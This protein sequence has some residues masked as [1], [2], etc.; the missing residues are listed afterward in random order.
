MKS[1]ED[2][3][4]RKENKT[5]KK[6]IGLIFSLLLGFCAV[7]GMCVS[8]SISNRNYVAVY[9]EP[10]DSSDG[11]A[12]STPAESDP[13]EAESEVFE[14]KVIIPEFEH[15]KIT[16]DKLEG[17]AGDIVTLEVKHSLFYLIDFVKANDVNLVEDE[18]TSG[19]YKFALVEGDNNI[20][21]KFI[22]DTELLGEMSVIY[23][24]A[25]NKDWTNLFSVENIFR[26]ASF[27]LSSGLLLAMVRYFI[28]DKRLESKVE[29]KV[30]STMKAIVPDM[31]KKVV[32]E[33]I[34]NVIEPIFAE[35]SANQV[36]IMRVLGALV[37]C[38]ALMQEDTPESRRAVLSELANLNIGDTK[39]I[40]DAK[41]FI[42]KYFN[43]KMNEL[44]GLLSSVDK[45]IEKNK[46]VANQYAKAPA[47][48]PEGF[49]GLSSKKDNGTQI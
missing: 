20:S 46:E 16:A 24:Q 28:K 17:H 32:E 42:D 27:I 40:E 7:G 49:S 8:H 12:E 4:N 11:P 33:N 35:T 1:L 29:N 15:G 38:M 30:E 6:R 43:D 25:S 5:M 37:K 41:A 31:T 22:V 9:A 47:D 44:Q 21:A 10:D 36:E 19:I 3:F 14:C 2:L 23:E 34:Q 26:I 45:V 39:V 13:V 48:E 18:E